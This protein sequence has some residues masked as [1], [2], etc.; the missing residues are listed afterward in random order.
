MSDSIGVAV[1]GGGMAGRAHAAGYRAATTLFGT[2]RPD[3]RLVAIAD[4]NEAVADDTAK[5]YGYERAEYDWQ[6]IADA[7]D[8]DA[9]SVVVA[10]HLHREIVEGLLAAGKHVLCEKPLAA[11]LAAAGGMVAA[12]QKSA[13]VPAVGYTYRRSPAVEMIRRELALGG[14]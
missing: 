11:S 4:M 7:P 2:D 3:V 13:R 14:L 12:A 9:V 1:I 8:V 10:N 6:G 5:R